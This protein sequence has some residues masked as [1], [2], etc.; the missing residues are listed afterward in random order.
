MGKFFERGWGETSMTNPSTSVQAQ[1][2]HMRA[3]V[4][5]DR[6]PLDIRWCSDSRVVKTYSSFDLLGEWRSTTYE[7][8]TGTFR[9]QCTEEVFRE[10]PPESRVARVRLIRPLGVSTHDQTLVVNLPGTGDD[11]FYRRE[12]IGAPLLH[13]GIAH[14]S[15][16]GPYYGNRKPRD[17]SGCRLGCVAD[18]FRLGRVTIEEGMRLLHWGEHEGFRS[19]G[20]TGLSMGAVHAAHVASHFP[21]E[22]ALAPLLA[23]HSAAPAYCFGL[24]NKGTAWSSLESSPPHPGLLSESLGSHHHDH[25]DDDTHAPEGGTN[26]SRNK[27]DLRKI[28]ATVRGDHSYLVHGAHNNNNNNTNNLSVSTIAREFPGLSSVALRDLDI[29]LTASRDKRRDDDMLRV[30]SWSSGQGSSSDASRSPAAIYTLYDVLT[31]F[32]D[33]TLL[34]PPVRRDAVVVV[35]AEEDEYV[36]RRSTLKLVDAWR[37]QHPVRWVKGGH[38]SSFLMHFET[39]QRAIYDSFEQLTLPYL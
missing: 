3:A 38:V 16:E 26:H 28:L 1:C 33:V 34:R 31:R 15:L 35:A 8:I 5:A 12:L 29:I 18:L 22:I 17:Q 25:D 27:L 14:A 23:P 30:K 11:T 32:T 19:V 21:R 20:V 39:F 4:C 6:R 2:E 36:P 13:H 9:A 7:M 24:L 10:L 37:L